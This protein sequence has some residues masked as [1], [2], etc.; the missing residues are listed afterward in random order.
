MKGYKAF[1]KGLICR[2]KQYAENQTF[3]EK[4]AIPC[5]KGM[6]FCENPF[7]VLDYYD[8]VNDSGEMSEFAEV[9]TPEDAVVNTED[10]E[11]YCTTKLKLSLKGF[12]EACVDFVLEKTKFT[13]YGKKLI[14]DESKDFSKIG[15]SGYG[16][17]IGSSG[18]G[19]QIGSSGYGAKIG[20]SGDGAK[21]RH[22]GHDS[23][24]CCAGCNS[25]VSAKKGCWITLSEW[26]M[27]YEKRRYVP[28]HVKTE[29]VDGERIKE[30]VL[31]TL[32]NGEFVEAE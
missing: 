29:Y 20:S 28:T 27:D 11:K 16:A 10:N 31:Y 32:K 26:E 21:I 7:Y 9:E 25:C 17:K 22:T 18:Y 14:S 1:D 24:I 4:E 3:E 13:D 5:C 12:V 8:L 19:A 2:G 6:H 23:V 15:S 30:D